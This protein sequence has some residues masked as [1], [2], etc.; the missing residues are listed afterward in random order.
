M[1]VLDLGAAGKIGTGEGAT[2]G[3]LAYTAPERLAGAALDPTADLWS[4]GVVLYEMITGRRAFVGSTS[5]AVIDAILNHAPTA[6]VEL[7][8]NVPAELVSLTRPGLRPC[9]PRVR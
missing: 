5:V 2:S 4:L 7:N 6:P 9:V 1:R 3:A 8:R